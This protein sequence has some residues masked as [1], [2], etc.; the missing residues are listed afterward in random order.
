MKQAGEATVNAAGQGTAAA[1]PDLPVTGQFDGLF[2]GLGVRSRM[3]LSQLPLTVTVVLVVVAAAVFNPSALDNRQ[4]QLALLAHAALF[5]ACLALPWNRLRTE[6]FAVIAVLDCL[7]IGFTREA[8][9]PPFNVMSLLLVFPVVWL[10]AQP[11]RYMVVLAILGTVLSTVVPSIVAGSPP[12]SASMIRTI[13]LPLILSAVAVT[14]HLVAGTI[15]RQRQRLVD[16]E[17]ALEVAL[18]E[19][20]RKQRLLDAVL[21]AVGIGVW[22]VDGNGGTVLTNKALQADPALAALP[23]NAGNGLLLPDRATSVPAD[24]TPVARAAAGVEFRDELYWAGGPKEQHAYSVS[25]HGIPARDGKDGGAVVTFVDVTTLIRA[26]AAKDDFVSTVS[27]ELRT[28][29]TS[30]LGYLEL[31]LEEPGHEDIREELLVVHRNAGHLLSLVNDLIAVASERVDLSLEEADL[32]QLVTEVVGAEAPKASLNGLRLHLD[33]EQPLPARFDPERIRQVVR[34][35]LS[36]AVKYSPGG[37]HI[38]VCA[39]K[40][41]GKLTCSVTDTGLGMDADEQE[42]A[43]TKFFRS[44]RSRATAIPGAGLGLPVSKTIV[45]G[46]GGAISLASEP[47]EGTTVTFTLPAAS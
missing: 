46:H 44:A 7:A 25:A 15:R 2:G 8:G 18:A 3:V 42:Q 43:F 22:V 35:L 27:H 13:F 29:L 4:F 26:L 30:I 45:E 11:R 28:P 21:G 6:A 39:R 5:A 23:G 33:V 10:A 41:G 32:A 38:T 36:N 1:P 31:V 20:V 34:N 16:K 19:S 24:A 17:N 9:G 40:S 12:T 37:G 47:G 14:A